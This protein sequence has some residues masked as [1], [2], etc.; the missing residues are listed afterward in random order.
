MSFGG[1]F[2]EFSWYS[3]CLL[4]FG[5]ALP[6]F[7]EFFLITWF[8][9]VCVFF[10]MKLYSIEFYWVYRVFWRPRLFHYRVLY[11]VFSF[12]GSVVGRLVFVFT[13]RRFVDGP[14]GSSR[15]SV[16]FRRRRW[17]FPVFDVAANGDAVLWRHRRPEAA[18]FFAYRL[19]PSWTH[20]SAT[21]T[22]SVFHSSASTSLLLLLL[23]L[24]LLR[25]CR[26]RVS[27]NGVAQIW[28]TVRGALM[29][30]HASRHPVMQMRRWWRHADDGRLGCLA[31]AIDTGWLLPSCL[32]PFLHGQCFTGFYWVLLGFTGFY[33]VLPGFLD[34]FFLGPMFYRVVLGFASCF[35]ESLE[36]ISSLSLF[37]E[38]T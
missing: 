23:L 28:G 7:T 24:L 17:A 2:I 12:V 10:L 36:S 15:V 13:F 6:G 19:V 21:F 30:T 16:E 11:R 18:G 32:Q 26:G 37:I 38:I 31:R 5:V 14:A 22:A 20:A 27:T 34:W 4:D 25:R 33:W 3:H 8:Q 29:S 35:A 9:Q 1:S